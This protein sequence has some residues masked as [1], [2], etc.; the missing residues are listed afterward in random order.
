MKSILLT[1]TA[2][3]AFAG[4]A[5]A[6]QGQLQPVIDTTIQ[7]DTG[8][9]MADGET[10]PS[11][12]PNVP[13]A[14]SPAGVEL[15]AD[16]EFG[17]NEEVE[18]GFYFNGGLGLTT[19]AGMNMGLTAGIDAD[20]D[21]DFT[22]NDTG[23]TAD[24]GTFDNADVSI[25][26]FVIYVEGQGAGFYVG[27]TETAAASRWSGTTNMQQDNFLEV[28]DIDDGALNGDFVDAVMRADLTYG[29]ISGSVSYLLTDAGD[30]PDLDGVDGLSVGVEGTFGS[31]VAGMAYQE[32]VDSVIFD[33]GPIDEKVGVYGGA[34]FAGADVKLAYARNLTTEEDS[35]GVQV[36][37][38]FGP[39]TATAFYSVE[40]LGDDNYGFGVVYANGPI[41]AGAYYHDGQDQEIG[42][43]ASYDLGNGLVGYAGYIGSNDGNDDYEFYVAAAYDLG[44]GAALIAS[45]GE[46]ST[47]NGVIG[48]GSDEIGNTYEV[49]EGVTVAVSFQF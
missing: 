5:S 2:L 47:Y 42:V 8:M 48:D 45:Y 49:N 35:I 43:E 25:S 30:N 13:A 46:D 28:D 18:G 23:S 31:F 12:I 27:D 40:S 9:I 10:L 36:D 1:T 34:T 20:I 21:I 32:E 44:G 11:D 4:M 6:Q 19:N 14:A 37:Y 29:D 33:G 22:D 24:G 41:T 26:D 7:S 15:G 38:P 39:V 3:V 16:G 17:Y